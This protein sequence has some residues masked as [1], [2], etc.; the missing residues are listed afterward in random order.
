M[1]QPRY[2]YVAPVLGNNMAGNPLDP[3]KR[4]ECSKLERHDMTFPKC[5]KAGDLVK[6]T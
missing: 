1:G 2:I 5:E 6:G 3:R 4:F